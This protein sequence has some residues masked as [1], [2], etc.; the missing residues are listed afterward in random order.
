MHYDANKIGIE[1]RI[2]D[3]CLHPLFIVVT[4]IMGVLAGILGG[5]DGVFTPCFPNCEFSYE[6]TSF[7]IILAGF[8]LCFGLTFWAQKRRSE[9]TDKLLV[10]I[11]EKSSLLDKQIRQLYTLPPEGFLYKYME[12]ISNTHEIFFVLQE[13]NDPPIEEIIIAT[14]TILTY[15]MELARGYDKDGLEANYGCNLMIFI[16][17]D[18]ISDD[19]EEIEKRLKF[20]DHGVS[21]KKLQGVL[22]LILPLSVSSSNTKDLDSNLNALALPVPS[23]SREK[24]SNNKILLPGAPL[25]FVE[26]TVTAVESPEDWNSRANP[27]SSKVRDE[28]K[29]FFMEQGEYIQ[30]FISIPLYD[31]P[32]FTKSREPIGILN[33]HRN[34]PNNL[35]AEKLQ[36]FY[37]LLVPYNILVGKLLKFY[38]EKSA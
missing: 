25:A 37:P 30:S 5:K 19:E 6:V 27:F 9:S 11:H 34:T 8:A 31:E 2:E 28:L 16:A 13:K 32:N 12:S 1:D 7:W 29:S 38:K 35:L 4:T 23:F 15:I 3:I 21:V 33:I 17:S 18:D 26:R 10:R 22:D 20:V 36:L 24:N 14:R